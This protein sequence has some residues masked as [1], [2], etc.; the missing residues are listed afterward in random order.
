MWMTDALRSL[1]NLAHVGGR[2]IEAPSIN[3]MLVDALVHRVRVLLRHRPGEEPMVS[4]I[5]HVE[6]T[7]I[8]IEDPMR[9][10]CRC[11][12]EPG[13]DVQLEIQMPEGVAS[14]TARVE[15]RMNLAEAGMELL[16][17]ALAVSD[18]RI[19]QG[20]QHAR[21]PVAYDIDL[22]ARIEPLGLDVHVQDI[23]VGGMKI[24]MSSDDESI[25][26]DDQVS[27]HMNAPCT[28]RKIR[29]D[30]RVVTVTPGRRGSC[31]VGL[32]FVHP[33]A[34]LEESVR[35]L[36]KRRANRYSHVA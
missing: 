35:M 32:Q 21:V 18:V 20:R 36:Q 24:R 13:S 29:Q 10:G 23:S 28:S 14:M 31:L 30:A 25:S 7:V 1:L 19:E 27:I 15:A 9:G 16:G 33:C 26:R 5:D 4:R 22:H 11:T 6:D 8:I 12:L 34:E 3:T 2:D 17:Y